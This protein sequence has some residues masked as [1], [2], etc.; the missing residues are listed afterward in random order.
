MSKHTKRN[1]PPSPAPKPA[2]FRYRDNNPQNL[3][4]D[5]DDEQFDALTVVL[6]ALAKG[7]YPR[8]DAVPLAL[9]AYNCINNRGDDNDMPWAYFHTVTL[10]APEGTPMKTRPIIELDEAIIEDLEKPWV[11]LRSG[12]GGGAR[13]DSARYRFLCFIHK[14][15][16]D[17]RATF[18]K[19]VHTISIWDREVS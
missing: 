1:A 5:L 2:P 19:G 13:Q 15:R 18:Q 17:R 3:I 12:G 10:V 14:H 8:L 11:P 9:N 16:I 4:P 6:R 7:S